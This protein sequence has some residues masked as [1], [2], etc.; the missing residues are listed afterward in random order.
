M[1]IHRI[2]LCSIMFPCFLLLLFIIFFSLNKNVHTPEEDP[3]VSSPGRYKY[4]EMKFHHYNHDHKWSTPSWN[5]INSTT[6]LIF[7]IHNTLVLSDL[8]F[9]VVVVVVNADTLF[10]FIKWNVSK[11]YLFLWFIAPCCTCLYVSGLT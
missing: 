6:F 4:I 3:K 1:A 5:F 10:T 2:K 11:I 8:P 9:F 7:I